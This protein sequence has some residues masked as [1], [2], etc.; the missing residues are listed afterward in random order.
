MSDDS[1]PQGHGL[2]S[3]FPSLPQNTRLQKWAP[4]HKTVTEPVLL[5]R[6]CLVVVVRI[7]AAAFLIQLPA[8]APARVADGP[9][10]FCTTSEPW[11]KLLVPDLS[12]AQPQLLQTFGE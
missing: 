2:K 3:F 11:M 6:L 1:L 12:L 10:S 9:I 5:K 4:L 7:P 8:H